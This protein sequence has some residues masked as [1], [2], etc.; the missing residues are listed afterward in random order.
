MPSAAFTGQSYYSPSGL[1]G[2][3]ASDPAWR[4]AIMAAGGSVGG[5]GGAVSFSA[6]VPISSGLESDG[7]TVYVTS[8]G[9]S[10]GTMVSEYRFVT[11]A[12]GWVEVSTGL[13]WGVSS[14]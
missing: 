4:Q 13:Q 5:G 8:N 12:G 6:T 10:T 11:S 3:L 7:D 1:I 2:A 14:W 9:T